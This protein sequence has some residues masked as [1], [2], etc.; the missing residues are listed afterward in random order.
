MT[1]I[2]IY[3]IDSEVLCAWLTKAINSEK[4]QVKKKQLGL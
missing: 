4:N 2:D 1:K 3:T